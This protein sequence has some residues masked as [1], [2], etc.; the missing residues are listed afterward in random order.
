MK[1]HFTNCTFWGFKSSIFLLFSQLLIAGN[2]FANGEEESKRTQSQ[3]IK[4]NVIIALPPSPCFT[5]IIPLN[6]TICA[7]ASVMLNAS[8]ASA[9]LTY[10]WQRNGSS[11]SGATGSTYSATLA[12]T[13]TL[14]ATNGS[15]LL[16]SDGA[17]VNVTITTT[18]IISSSFT[19]T[20]GSQTVTMSTQTLPVGTF[21]WKLNGSPISGAISPSYT[22]TVVGSYT[23]DYTS[24]TCTATSSAFIFNQNTVPTV[25]LTPPVS[26][27][28]SS[29]LTAT[30]CS[31]AV[32]WER[33]DVSWVYV[34]FGN[35][36]TVLP[37]TN[38]PAEWRAKCYLNGCYSTPSNV[39]KAIPNNFTE[40]TTSNPVICTGG[41][42]LLNASSSFTGLTY[43]WKLN[44]GNISGATNSSYSATV[45]GTYSLTVTNGSCSYTSAGAAIT[46]STP[47]TPIISSSFTGTCG[48]QTVTMSTQTLPAGTF[49]WKLNGSPISGATSS[50]YTTTVVGSYTV[51]YT[52]NTC[53]ATSLAFIFNQNTVPT[54]ALI[55]PVSP[56]CSSTL[57]ATGCSGTVYWERND[58]SWVY[59]PFG[60]PFT[61]LPST[62]P[63]AEWRAK[64]Y[65][66]GCYSTPS[67]VVKAIPNN[68]TEVTAVSP[69]IVCN[70]GST[71]LNAS[72]S[73]VG[74]T[75]QWRLS[76]V[77]ISGATSS[78]YSATT[79]GQYSVTVTNGS[80]TFTSGSLNIS[81]FTGTIT[82]LTSGDW[83]NPTTWSCNCIPGACNNVTVDTGHTVT[84]PPSLTG[85]L[86]NLT[87]KGLVSPQSNGIMKMGN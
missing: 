21:Q 26:P 58:V 47:T 68:F 9:G 48:S 49:Q 19:G 35:P 13:Y 5:E 39:V 16:T 77:N 66:N 33:N 23:V 34:P 71:L 65:L 1:N 27:N 59:V 11:I 4:D 52:S 17:I 70:T 7:G 50:S 72:S 28:C 79:T 2:L 29:T 22:T 74:L 73:S 14:T 31:G 56:N 51:D 76:N 86:K 43:Q 46:V 85:K 25:A 60:N 18:P 83:T 67:N 44:G 38:P 62:N 41:S 69:F 45:A 32:Y 54:V 8:S 15:C 10:Q 84:I 20:C 81:S 6:S 63:P 87:L 30:G 3:P 82:S 12:G 40:V 55:P 36:F 64:C 75:Y 37:S 42:T 80:C 53:T 57:T 61:V 24:N 78:S